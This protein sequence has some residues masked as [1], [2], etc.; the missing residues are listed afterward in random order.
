[1]E[2][3]NRHVP[4]SCCLSHEVLAP[5]SLSFLAQLPD[6]GAACDGD[7]D[8]NMILGKAFFV[9]PSDSVALIAAYAQVLCFCHL[10]TVPLGGQV[11][12]VR[13]LCR[14]GSGM[15]EAE[16]RVADDS[17]MSGLCAEHAV[18]ASCLTRAGFVW[19][20]WNGLMSA[21]MLNH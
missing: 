17:A 2:A 11:S 3:W 18:T 15:L 14:A 8:R 4:N 21:L 7:A 9:T 6:F 20:S 5:H 10:T 13:P 1:M 12:A 16:T 19:S